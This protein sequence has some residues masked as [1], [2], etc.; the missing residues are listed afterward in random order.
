MK[1]IPNLT[2]AA[3]SLMAFG[4][5]T[6]F[7]DNLAPCPDPVTELTFSY[8]YNMD[9]QDYFKNEVHCLDLYIFDEEG[10]LVETHHEKSDANIKTG[11][12]KVQKSL[13]PGKYKVIVYGGTSCNDASFQ[14]LFT[15]DNNLK[16]TDL[17]VDMKNAYYYLTSGNTDA[18]GS[19]YSEL[20][21]EQHKN[22]ELHPLFY[23]YQEFEVLEDIDVTL[24]PTIDM[25]RDTNRVYVTVRNENGQPVNKSDIHLTI[26]DDNNTFDYQN[27]IQKTG[28]IN[29]RP[30]LKEDK[31]NNTLS[32]EFTISRLMDTHSPMIM[33]T[34][35][36]PRDMNEEIL[37]ANLLDKISKYKAEKGGAIA[38]MPMQ[39]YLDREYKW[40]VDVE[41]PDDGSWIDAKIEVKDWD[42][43]ENPVYDYE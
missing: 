19:F 30:Y 34:S 23:G 37:K 25:Q 18:P 13:E 35:G 2:A 39:E 32:S 36:D 6:M 14:K 3:I 38:E 1:L 24:V 9:F 15:E 11:G 16:I 26:Q 27:N 21:E 4:S 20:T 22:L 28:N 41:L 29:Y 42:V 17:K 10:A 31:T 12:F 43:I 8:A 7:N 5:C 33:I 40:Y